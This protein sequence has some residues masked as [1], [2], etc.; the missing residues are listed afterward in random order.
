VKA[1]DGP[2]DATRCI[3]HFYPKIIVFSVLG[4][5]GNIVFYI[6]LRPIK[7]NLDG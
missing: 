3:R 4:S 5:M 2:I 7:K 1:E 6:F